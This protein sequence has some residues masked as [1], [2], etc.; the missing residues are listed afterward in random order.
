MTPSRLLTLFNNLDLDKLNGAGFA[1]TS[2][3]KKGRPRIFST[4]CAAITSAAWAISNSAGSFHGAKRSYPVGYNA[5]SEYWG[6]GGISPGHSTGQYSAKNS[7]WRKGKWCWWT[8][9]APMLEEA[10]KSIP[11]SRGA[12]RGTTTVAQAGDNFYTIAERG[13]DGNSP[14][15]ASAIAAL[16]DF[17]A[18]LTTSH[19]HGRTS[20]AAA[21]C[22]TEQNR[23]R[24]PAGGSSRIPDGRQPAPESDVGAPTASSPAATPQFAGG[25]GGYVCASCCGGVRRHPWQN[26]R[27]RRRGDRRRHR[28]P[29]STLPHK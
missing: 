9:R 10:A 12:V 20:V 4:T 7:G 11:A 27:P 25:S 1:T 22:A 28:S 21:V 16:N 24:Q 6:R 15:P 2:F 3:Y 13:L 17:H 23:R 8:P 29:W 18:A 19:P 5:N 14:G 26:G